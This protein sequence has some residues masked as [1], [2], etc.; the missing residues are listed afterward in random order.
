MAC[1]LSFHLFIEKEMFIAQAFWV[2]F[3]FF[4]LFFHS[5]NYEYPGKQFVLCVYNVIARLDFVRAK[6]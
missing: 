4:F 2:F 6:V 5:S 1:A 3:F